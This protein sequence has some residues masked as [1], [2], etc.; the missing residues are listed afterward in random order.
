MSDS[1]KAVVAEDVD[2]KTRVSIKQLT[3]GDLPDLD[4]LVE[5]AYS[6][7][8][9][10]DGLAVSGKGKI[11]RRLPMVC[12][13]DLAGTV[14]ESKSPDWQPGDKVIVNGFGLS[15]SQ[16]GGYSQK[17]RVKS[18]WLI[19]LPSVFSLKQA[20]AIGTAG[21]TAMLCVLGLEQMG[22][23]PEG[24]EVLVTGGA[25]GVGSVAIAVLAR[26]GY[27]VIAS[28]GRAET[29]DYLKSLGA[30]G[31]I[32]RAA[33]LEKGP[34]LQK[35]RWA[36]AVDSVGSQTLANVL[37]QIAY[38]GA[39]AACGLAGG[40]DLPSTVLPFILRGVSLIGIDSVM[41]PRARRQTAWDRL[42]RD[43]DRA[44]LDAMTTV[45]PMSQLPQLAEQIL[46]GQVRGR[47]VI[48]V[49]A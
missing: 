20:M 16:W 10:K 37:A 3:L 5:V 47:M 19:R 12:G 26:L 48:D 43:L 49:N 22:V 25:G 41:A 28:T 31:C 38:G 29:H 17:Q 21:Y 1:F 11:A 30:V 9:Y 39:V 7:L 35:E 32:D 46:K 24:R 4:V 34:P 18:D 33:L 23:R 6:T 36:G 2:G 42:A 45:E 8:N 27:K 40:S 13:I 14:L 15:E 44:K